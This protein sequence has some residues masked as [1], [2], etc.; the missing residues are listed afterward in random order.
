[1]F[2]EALANYVSRPDVMQ[3]LASKFPLASGVPHTCSVSS[4]EE[5]VY[6]ISRDSYYRR[7]QASLMLA[8]LQSIQEVSKD[9]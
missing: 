7:K 1:M 9:A 6:S 4:L 2:K 8:G 3:K 5:A